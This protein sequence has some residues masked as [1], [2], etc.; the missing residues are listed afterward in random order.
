MT[1]VAKEVE[2]LGAGQVGEGSTDCV[3][4]ACVIVFG[5]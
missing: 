4:M 2:F 3:H 5:G 1:L